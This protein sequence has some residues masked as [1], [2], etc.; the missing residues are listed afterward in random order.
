MEMNIQ[1]KKHFDIVKKIKFFI[2]KRKNKKALK[3]RKYIY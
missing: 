2:W 3:R 1:V